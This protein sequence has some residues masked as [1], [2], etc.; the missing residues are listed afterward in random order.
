MKILV[1][2]QSRGLKNGT[3]SAIRKDFMGIRVWLDDIRPM[4]DGYDMWIKDASYMKRV[5]EHYEIDHISFDHDLGKGETGYSVACFIEGLAAEK[6]IKPMTYD[7]HSSN[8]EGRR[9]IEKA[10]SV[11]ERLWNNE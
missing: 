8:P 2:I 7:I 1:R 11:A 9:Y 5:I 10:M 6:K 4:P 3:T